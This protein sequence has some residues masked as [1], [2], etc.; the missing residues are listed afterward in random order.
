MNFISIDLREQEIKIKRYKAKNN[1]DLKKII[2]KLEQLSMDGWYIHTVN[3]WPS[4]FDVN[5]DF[6]LC[7]PRKTRMQELQR[8]PK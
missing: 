2:A 1:S 7:R 8:V 5:Y 6:Y 4:P 3:S